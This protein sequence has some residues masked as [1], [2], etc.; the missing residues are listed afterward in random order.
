MDI[1]VKILQLLLGIMTLIYLFR[2]FSEQFSVMVKRI[3]L[4]TVWQAYTSLS[5]L[6]CETLIVISLQRLTEVAS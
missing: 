4:G 2:D 6:I 5:V 1:E 3:A